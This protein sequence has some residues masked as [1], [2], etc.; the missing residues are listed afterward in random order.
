MRLFNFVWSVVVFFYYATFGKD[1]EF[2]IWHYRSGNRFIRV[3]NNKK[4]AVLAAS[5]TDNFNVEF[6]PQSIVFQRLYKLY[7]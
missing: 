6:A 1:V 7:F 5:G 3:Y 4:A 2:C